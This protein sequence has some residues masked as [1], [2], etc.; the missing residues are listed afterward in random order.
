MSR[1]TILG[2]TVTYSAVG[3][4]FTK[5]SDGEAHGRYIM[6]D[7]AEVR[8]LD[9]LGAAALLII[10]LP[11]MALVA[12]AVMITSRGPILF[13]QKRVGRDGKLFECLKFRTMQ[14]D[15][16]ARLNE[17]LIKDEAALREWTETQKLRNDPRITAVGQFL[18]KSSLDELPQFWNVLRGDMSLVGPRPIVPDE[19]VRYGK[20]IA[21]YYAVKP[22]ITGLWQV[23]GRNDTSYRRRVA[24][25]VVYA[26][27]GTLVD[28]VKILALTVPSVLMSKGTY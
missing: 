21:F 1:C 20:Y 7:P 14:I 8:L 28:N 19:T 17:L 18:R 13:R 10:F 4:E 2:G 3:T 24:Y 22:G 12:I 26:R 25:D 23:N 6:D 16:E 27:K 11:L 5:F 9:I 15:A